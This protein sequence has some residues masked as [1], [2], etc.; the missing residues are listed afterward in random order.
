MD[1]EFEKTSESPPFPIACADASGSHSPRG[2]IPVRPCIRCCWNDMLHHTTIG[3]IFFAFAVFLIRETEVRKADDD[4]H[5]VIYDRCGVHGGIVGPSPIPCVYN[6]PPIPIPSSN[7]IYE[8]L[9]ETCP[10]FFQDLSQMAVGEMDYYIS[11]AYVDG[12]YDSCDNVRYGPTADLALPFLC[13]FNQ[14]CMPHDMFNYLGNISN[15]QAPF[16][17]NYLY[18]TQDEVNGF[19]PM[20]ATIVECSEPVD[21]DA[22]D[23]P[24]GYPCAC[25]DCPEA[26]PMSLPFANGLH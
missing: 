18:Q 21:P 16:Q 26:C 7:P 11:E 25:R 20:N 3:A 4:P 17:I 9:L 1:M 6:G 8:T 5:C 23:T 14:N 2:K 22:L 12:T 19:K 13:G 15:G 10:E 24:E